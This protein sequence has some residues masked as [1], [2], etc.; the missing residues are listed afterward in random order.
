MSKTNTANIANEIIKKITKMKLAKLKSVFYPE[1]I[2]VIIIAYNTR[3]GL[4]RDLV[5]DI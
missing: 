3:K 4:I 2:G 5:Q 1:E